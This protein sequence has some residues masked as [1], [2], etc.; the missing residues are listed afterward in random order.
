MI[1]QYPVRRSRDGNHGKP[2]KET[3]VIVDYTGVRVAIVSSQPLRTIEEA[4]QM[5]KDICIA[6]NKQAGCEVY[7]SKLFPYKTFARRFDREVEI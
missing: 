3:A 6:L 4:R 5:A 7:V 2:E 1:I